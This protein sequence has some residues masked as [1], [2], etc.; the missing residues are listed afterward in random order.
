M[1]QAL[2]IDASGK[3]FARAGEH[4]CVGIRGSQFRKAVDQGIAEFDIER[5]G[6][7]VLHGEHGNALGH[8]AL[9]HAGCS[10]AAVSATRWRAPCH[11]RSACTID[12][13]NTTM[14]KI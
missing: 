2:E 6:L 4:D 8:C 12:A 5:I 13:V 7:A 10:A 9:D 11:S 14:A 1:A 3:D